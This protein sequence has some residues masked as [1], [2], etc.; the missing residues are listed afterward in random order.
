[1]KLRLFIFALSVP[2]LSWA[3]NYLPPIVADNK[4]NVSRPS[5][6][7]PET[8][9]GAY[10]GTT[11]R[12]T[13]DRA[14]DFVNVK[15]FG[16]RGNGSDATAAIRLAIAQ[17]PATGGT[18]LI[19]AGNYAISGTNTLPS[20]THL[21]CE[22]AV[23]TAAAAAKWPG[24]Q[25]GP[26]FNQT[27]G[28]NFE[29]SGCNFIY[30]VGTPDALTVFGGGAPHILQFVGVSHVFVH[31]NFFTGSNNDV[32]N[33]GST[34]VWVL[35][36]T[37]TNSNNGCYD[38]WAGFTDAHVNSNYCSIVASTATGTDGIS[39]TGMNTD[40]SGSNS[41]G[42]EALGNT[43][44]MGNTHA[45]ACIVVNGH[46]SSGADNDGRIA[47]NK[48]VAGS[49]VYTWGILVTG[50]ANNIDIHDNYC[51]GNAGSY[52]CVGSYA[53]ATNIKIHDNFAYNWKSGANGVFAN[54]AVGGSLTFNEGLSSSSPLL[55]LVDRSTLQIGNDTGT[56]TINEADVKITSG[57]ASF[58]GG[59]TFNEAIAGGAAFTVQ[60]CGAA[61]S[62]TGGAT[63]GSFIVGSGAPSCT[64]VITMGGAV[65][66][67]HGW[68]CSASDQTAGISLP[69]SG[70]STTTCSVKGKSSANDVIVFSA[71]GY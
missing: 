37:A 21:R 50:K 26:A 54:N 8:S 9:V 17:I 60:G 7:S 56:G 68:T 44:V 4:T 48:C 19:P 58:S 66:A 24:G 65:S 64:F 13:A 71:I 12:T 53:P 43:I 57:S 70:N 28:S 16:A 55:G 51:E 15:D 14:A 23:I 34:D 32:A 59:V 46:G 61:R 29:I 40:G 18:L 2:A 69:Q 49:G 27:T 1:M 3:Q 22:G 35:S 25:T 42:F 11:T 41:I 20:H 6:D 36:N 45:P 5:L 38:N 47:D 62:V 63:A 39:F 67:T 31:N 10:G 33:V 30:P 52:S